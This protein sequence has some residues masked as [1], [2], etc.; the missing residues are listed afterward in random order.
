MVARPARRIPLW[1]QGANGLCIEA[2]LDERKQ[3]EGNLSREAESTS[4]RSVRDDLESQRGI[5]QR[6]RLCG[7]ALA[8]RMERRLDD[9]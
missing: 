8:A 3:A 9:K 2:V 1:P 7:L 4:D 6:D 5:M